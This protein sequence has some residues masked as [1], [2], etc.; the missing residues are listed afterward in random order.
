[1]AGLLPSS[2]DTSDAD[3]GDPRVIGLDSDAADELLSA[4]SSR[5]ARRVLAALHEEPTTPAALA[6]RV[7]TSLQNAQYHLGSL[8]EAGIVEVVGTAYSEKGREMKVYGPS[9]RALVVV[10]GREEETN[11][12]R[13]LLSRLVGGVGVLGVASLV[14][15]RLLGGPT[16]E[17]SPFAMGSD[18][19]AEGQSGEYTAE[20]GDGG[21]ATGGGGADGDAGDDADSSDTGDDAGDDAG[22]Y[23]ASADGNESVTV[24]EP[25]ET[26]DG[27]TAGVQTEA[28]VEEGAATQTPTETARSDAATETYAETAT[29]A[30]DGGTTTQTAAD[31]ATEVSGGVFDAGGQ[32]LVDVLVASPGFLFFLG[33]VAVLLVAL[34]V[35]SRR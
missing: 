13:A 21:S 15:D 14:V 16:A 35:R 34:Y 32:S 31:A 19:G 24:S 8:E 30:D 17:F 11:G 1:M 12:L 28:T 18:G 7:D 6:E 25:T 26:A 5:T 22:E 3:P 20:A 23:D 27:T 10:A 2:P 4:L 9:D 29:A 33:G